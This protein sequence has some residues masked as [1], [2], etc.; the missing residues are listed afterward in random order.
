MTL[1][2]TLDKLDLVFK[3]RDYN[4]AYEFLTSIENIKTNEVEH[5]FNYIIYFST[6]IQNIQLLKLVYH[7]IFEHAY[8]FEDIHSLIAQTVSEQKKYD[9]I[10]HT[11]LA[12]LSTTKDYCF[13][14]INENDSELCTYILN[15][16][17][18]DFDYQYLKD[19]YDELFFKNNLDVAYLLK[20]TVSMNEVLFH[21]CF[22]QSIGSPYNEGIDYLMSHYP[23]MT[24]EFMDNWLKYI[25]HR[26]EKTSYDEWHLLTKKDIGE[27]YSVS[28]LAHTVNLIKENCKISNE[29]GL[30]QYFLKPFLIKREDS[31]DTVYQFLNLVYLQKQKEVPFFILSHIDEHQNKK[32]EENFKNFSIYFE[33]KKLNH[34]ISNN[35]LDLK[36]IKL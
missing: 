13:E 36:K 2:E 23:K 30:M 12:N 24:L 15:H 18:L 9:F 31:F 4:L 33:Q 22:L 7:P 1:D 29:E 25:D 10:P 21:R 3:N 32:G 26:K 17:V 16:S 27:S 14:I 5:I 11:I 8:A 19:K 20:D 35:Q 34:T 6:E 28:T